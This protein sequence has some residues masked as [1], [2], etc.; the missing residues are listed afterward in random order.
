VQWTA[1]AAADPHAV[2]AA[3]TGAQSVATGMRGMARPQR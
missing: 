3:T 1:G 2:S